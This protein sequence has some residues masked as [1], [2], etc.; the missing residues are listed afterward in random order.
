MSH[1]VATILT[2]PQLPTYLSDTCALEQIVGIPTKD[3]VKAIHATIRALNSVSY[4]P[5]LFDPDLS[6]Q[7]AQHLF[8]SQMAI[9]Q[10]TRSSHRPSGTAVYMPPDLPPDIPGILNRV[11][12]APSDE[13]IQSVQSVVRHI[14]S[15]SYN[16]QLF[17]ANL[18]M[19]LSQHLFDIQLARH[20]YNSSAGSTTPAGVRMIV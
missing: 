7:L 11:I 2:P 16:P 9:H 17:D 10:F 8:D 14:E 15:Q 3:N 20:T 4:L 18:K 5:S 6:M 12:G 19:E 13:Q 1:R